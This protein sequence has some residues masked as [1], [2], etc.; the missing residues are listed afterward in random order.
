MVHFCYT[1]QEENLH[2]LPWPNSQILQD[3]VLSLE[4][5]N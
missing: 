4:L 3:N 2:N 5:Q 1:D